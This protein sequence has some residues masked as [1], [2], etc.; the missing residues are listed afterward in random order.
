LY[1]FPGA[2]AS[3]DWRQVLRAQTQQGRQV[4]RQILGPIR[5]RDYGNGDYTFEPTRLVDDDGTVLPIGDNEPWWEA[6][7][8]PEG[9]LVG[10]IQS[11]ASPTGVVPEW[12]RE[13][14]GEVKAA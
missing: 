7:V 1:A 13:V 12:T 2:S 5:I 14:P 4:V 6:D 11:V 9:L 3:A 8:Q 10:L